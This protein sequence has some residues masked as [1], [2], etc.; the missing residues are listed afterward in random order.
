MPGAIRF[1]PAKLAQNAC[2]QKNM[3]LKRLKLHT[4]KNY[5][6]AVIHFQPGVNCVVGKNG[7]G[8]TNLLDAIHYLAL[9]KT[10]LNIT[11]AQ[12]IRDGEGLF[13]VHGTFEEDFVVAC[14]FERGKGKTLKVNGEE[15]ARI[16]RHVGRL[17][18]VLTT[19]DDADIIREG[20]E[21]RRR[22]FDGAIAQ[23]DADYLQWL[24]DYN[25]VLKQRNELLKQWEGRLQNPT[26][27]DTYDAT[28]VPLA[29]KISQRRAS[30]LEQFA[31]SFRR[32]YANLHATNEEPTILLEADAL[33]N[34]FDKAF[35]NSRHKDV[36]MQRTLLGAHRDQYEFRLN[37]RPVRK[38]GSQ[39]QQKTF[40]IALKLA[41]YD[42]LRHETGKVP[43]LLLDD[44]FDKLDDERIGALVSVLSDGERF[45]QL[46]ITDARR[47]RSEQFFAAQS[48]HVIEIENGKVQ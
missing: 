18:V 38:F 24:I 48:V 31:E 13:T 34:L 25:R 16:S 14:A 12:A 5:P 30:F 35:A 15:E 17:P 45:A 10:A 27:L 32:N 33:T 39:G 6:E 29:S 11:D 4:F 26:L 37:D 7:S 3:I 23:L 2:L 41:E 46:F 42:L 22:F 21:T 19:P 47:E 1:R 8:K 44:I 20:S 9:G 43:L 28:L 36:M 40:I